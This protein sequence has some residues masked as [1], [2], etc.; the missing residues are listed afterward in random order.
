MSLHPFSVSIA[1]V[2]PETSPARARD[3]DAIGVGRDRSP[4]ERRGGSR[5]ARRE[6]DATHRAARYL[7]QRHAGVDADDPH[8]EDWRPALEQ[9]IADDVMALT[10][11]HV[12]LRGRLAASDAGGRRH[13]LL[14]GQARASNRP[15]AT[16]GK[17]RIDSGSPSEGS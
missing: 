13:S 12:D 4:I 16:C 5:L 10:F 1:R 15:Q 17:F 14:I 8:G 9:F 6:L 11:C 7:R 2:S 3:A